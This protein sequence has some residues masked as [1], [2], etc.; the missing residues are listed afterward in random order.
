[1]QVGDVGVGDGDGNI[2]TVGAEPAAETVV[3]VAGSEV[4]VA[5]FGVAF[6]ASSTRFGRIT[7]HDSPQK[8]AEIQNGAKLETAPILLHSRHT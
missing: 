5:G 1:L 3:V 2:G 7:L 8:P 4:V 6:F